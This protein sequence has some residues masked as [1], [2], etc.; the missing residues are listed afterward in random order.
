MKSLIKNLLPE[1]LLIFKRRV[2][3]TYSL[4]ICNIYDLYRYIKYSSTYSSHS[5]EKMLGKLVLY[6]H[7]IEKGLSFENRRVAFKMSITL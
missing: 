7:V 1:P 5:Q 6:Y 2:F 4:F 3:D